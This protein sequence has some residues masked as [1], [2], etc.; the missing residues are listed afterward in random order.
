MQGAGV[1]LR[2]A[3]TL[4]YL[5]IS[6]RKVFAMTT[7]N[8]RMLALSVTVLCPALFACGGADSAAAPPATPANSV[9]ES[10]KPPTTTSEPSTPSSSP[11]S[12]SSAPSTPTANTPSAGTPASSAATGA[13][14][15]S[16]SRLSCDKEVALK[17]PA[18][19]VDGC[20][21]P[22]S[23]RSKTLTTFHVCM[24]DNQKI[25]VSCDKEIALKCATGNIDACLVTPR[26]SEFHIC[27]ANSK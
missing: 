15:T 13:V 26:A 16:N 22:S 7:L 1:R 3:E 25:G 10:P 9:A 27:V 14:P 19:Q 24:P 2:P 18:G 6:T 8:R 23:G 5:P 17:C 4:A 11:A 12:S 20:S 21:H